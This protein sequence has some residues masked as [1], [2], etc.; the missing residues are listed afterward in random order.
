MDS[1]V[2]SDLITKRVK[3]GFVS[4]KTSFLRVYCHYAFERYSLRL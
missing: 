4:C 2:K 1:Q 3:A